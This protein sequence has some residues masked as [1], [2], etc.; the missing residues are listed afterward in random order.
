MATAAYPATR[1]EIIDSQGRAFVGYYEPGAVVST[2]DDDRTIKVFVGQ[3]ISADRWLD[4]KLI[5]PTATPEDVVDS[6]LDMIQGA[7][8]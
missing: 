7:D 3:P 6:M 4:G 8:S 5:V 1:V 2:Q